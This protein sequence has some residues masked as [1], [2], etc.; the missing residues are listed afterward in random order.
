MSENKKN[1]A[2]NSFMYNGGCK[3]RYLKLKR[4]AYYHAADRQRN[5]RIDAEE[6]SY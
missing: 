1:K 5:K 3:G 4:T 6:W 2:K